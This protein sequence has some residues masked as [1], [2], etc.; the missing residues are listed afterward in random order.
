MTEISHFQQIFEKY[1]QQIGMETFYFCQC[2]SRESYYE[3]LELMANGGR[4]K[5]NQTVYQDTVWCPFAYERGEWH[6]YPS[7]SKKLLFPPSSNVKKDG[8]YYIVMPV[9]QGKICIGYSIIG[10]FQN[11]VS[12]RVL[13]HL[14]LDI[15]AALG[16]IYR[17]D[18]MNTMLAKINQ[19]WQYD[20][21][22]GL[23]NRSGY[24]N[25]AMRLIDEAKSKGQ[26]ICAIFFDLNGLKKVNDEKG[27]EA[28]DQYIK[29]MADTLKNSADVTDIVC[30]YG[31]DEYIVISAQN[32]C[33]DCV[34]KLNFINSNIKEPLSVSAGYVFDFV[35]DMDGLNLLIEEA[36]KRM[37]EYKKKMKRERR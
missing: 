13:Q 25:N 33:E 6:S 14:V 28:G 4:I 5:R 11:C 36:D 26:G 34:K 7:Y 15:D 21:L 30:R 20:E 22:T 9:H 18:I 24:V 12:G 23:Y 29:S 8:S 35:S 27:H 31:G 16:H 17:N 1:I 3:E 10:N 19:K 37:Y 32:S 2:G